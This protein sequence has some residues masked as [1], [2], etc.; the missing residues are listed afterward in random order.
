MNLVRDDHD[1]VGRINDIC[2]LDAR[3]QELLKLN[4]L[5]LELK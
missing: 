1:S 3:I 4:K 2:K 5:K